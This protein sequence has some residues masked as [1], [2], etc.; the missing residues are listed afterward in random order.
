M[1]WPND[2]SGLLGQTVTLEGTAENRKVGGF[3]SGPS[4]YG[5]WIDAPHHWPEAC[6]SGA[7]GKR[8][9][10]TGT[11]IQR[12]DLPVFVARPGEP[13]VAGIPVQSEE[14]RNRA[15]WR[16]LLTGVHWTV[17]E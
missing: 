12:S 10:V 13:A 14:E 4:G 3:L 15:K 17:L 6:F 16:F 5:I 8:L 7:Q 1:A 2:W 11:V 9:R